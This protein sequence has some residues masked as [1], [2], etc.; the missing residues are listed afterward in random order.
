MSDYEVKQPR[1]KAKKEAY[2]I[3]GQTKELSKDV[4]NADKAGV[5]YGKFIGMKH[6]KEGGIT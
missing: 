2:R 6:E 5:S 3:P 1:K 4:Y